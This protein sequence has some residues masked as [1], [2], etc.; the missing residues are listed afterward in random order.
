MSD[1]TPDYEET[2]EADRELWVNVIYRAIIDATSAGTGC[3]SSSTTTTA[4]EC[5]RA[6]S[7]FDL[8]S[9][10]FIEVCSLAGLDPEA[11]Y[12]KA[13]RAIENADRN[14]NPRI[15]KRLPKAPPKQP[16]EAQ[17][18]PQ[19][20]AHRRSQPSNNGWHKFGAEAQRYT[21]NGVSKTIGQWAMHAGVPYVTMHSR[22]KSGMSIERAITMQPRERT[23]TFTHN[24]ETKLLA[25]WAQEVGMRPDTLSQR[26]RRGYSLAEALARPLGRSGRPKRNPT[27]QG[28]QGVIKNFGGVEG[29]GAGST[30]QEI[31]DLSFSK[32]SKQ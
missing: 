5:S 3:S 28:T 9:P 22:L 17:G 12:E 11:V 16:A 14:G 29:T 2:P 15:S 32:E 10:D 27:R 13:Q 7:W 8:T 1:N 20:T 19:P 23:G 26:L 31:P 25:E 30:A 21:Y 6:R 24:G 4:R 18:Q